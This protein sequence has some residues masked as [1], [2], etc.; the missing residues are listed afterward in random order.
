MALTSKDLNDLARKLA[1]TPTQREQLHALMAEH[2]TQI[3]ATAADRAS[4]ML[5]TPMQAAAQNPRGFREAQGL[6]RQ[7]GFSLEPSNTI[8]DVNA[9]NAAFHSRDI[10]Q[11]MRAKVC[12]RQLGLIGA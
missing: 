10:D 7:L 11:R 6:C 1:L 9:L 12:L 3:N 8:L 2:V 4:T 5:A